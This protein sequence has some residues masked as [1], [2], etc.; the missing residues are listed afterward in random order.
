MTGSGRVA[1][2]LLFLTGLAGTG[3]LLTAA[4]T[5]GDGWSRVLPIVVVATFWSVCI[6]DRELEQQRRFPF[7]YRYP[8][9]AA[10][11]MLA[12][13]LGY[14]IG[15]HRLDLQFYGLI[16]GSVAALASGARGYLITSRR[17][18]AL[19]QSLGSLSRYV[20]DRRWL[21]TVRSRKLS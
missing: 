9:E 17:G 8:I 13:A 14:L 5:A 10:A 21:S 1:E 20:R 15:R 12:L 4:A 11:I 7:L 3:L 19:D 2:G 16:G 6:P 18:E